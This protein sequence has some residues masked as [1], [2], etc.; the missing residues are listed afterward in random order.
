MLC[1][2]PVQ[3]IRSGILA[4]SLVAGLL[5]TAQAEETLPT[6]SWSRT[7][8]APYFIVQ[9]PYKNQGIGD[10]LIDYFITKIPEY[11]HLPEE[12]TLARMLANARNEIPVCHVALLKTPERELFIEYS[13][14]VM[15]NYANGLITNGQGLAHF[16]MSPDNITDI[17]LAAHS[18]HPINIMVTQGR[19][20]SAEVDSII[21]QESQLQ[22]SIFQ[23]KSGSTGHD[24]M[25]RLLAA[26]RIEGFLGRP[27]EAFFDNI[28]YEM[29]QTLYLI[30]LEGQPKASVV[31]VGCSKGS[32]NDDLLAE[33]N[34]LIKQ[35]E[36]QTFISSVYTRWLPEQL[37]ERYALD[38]AASFEQSAGAASQ[39]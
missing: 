31:H 39:P 10:Q 2:K 38:K 6:V 13:D 23:F 7:D 8:F 4:T 28:N 22:N 37:R 1:F 14:P 12:M 30:G 15:I 18:G 16:G 17:D 11:Q 27:E 34:R 21:K 26:N 32:W 33:I 5:P 3:L 19:S 24:Q 35:P 29:K 20:Y 9:G 25:I 36:V